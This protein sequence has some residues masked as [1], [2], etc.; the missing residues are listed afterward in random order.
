M[1]VVIALTLLTVATLHAVSTNLVLCVEY[2]VQLSLL[3]QAFIGKLPELPRVYLS[4]MGTWAVFR[5][6]Y[7]HSHGKG[8]VA[9]LDGSASGKRN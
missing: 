9:Q 8:E 1:V 7:W 5:F 2:G 3:H 6:W 4:V